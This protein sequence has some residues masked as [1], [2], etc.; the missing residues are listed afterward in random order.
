MTP[1]SFQISSDELVGRI[2]AYYYQP[3]FKLLEEEFKKCPWPLER[4]DKVAT[5]I[6]GSTPKDGSFTTACDDA[7]KFLKTINVQDY[8]LDLDTLYYIS[9]EAHRRRAISALKENDVLINIIGA[10]LEIVGRVTIVPL[11]FGEANINQNIARIRIK[12]NLDLDPYYLMGYLGTKLAQTQIEKLSRQ[13][14]Q[15]NLNTRE[16]GLILIPIPAK[17]IQVEVAEIVRKSSIAKKEAA[18]D[19][20]IA[21]TEFNDHIMKAFGIGLGDDKTRAF[22]VMSTRL[23]F[24]IDAEYYQPHY[25]ELESKLVTRARPLT[26]FVEFSSETIDPRKSPDK[27]FRYVEIENLDDVTASIS[28]YQLVKGSEAPSRARL[29]LRS[30]DIILPSLRGTFK[31]IVVVS[32]EFDGC[33]GTTGFLLLKPTRI[34]PKYLFAILK[35]KIG[36]MQFERAVTGAIMPALAQGELSKILIPYDM[37]RVSE[38]AEAANNFVD[39]TRLLKYR[40][41]TA[42]AV[43]KEKIQRTIMGK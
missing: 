27:E 38:I 13:A 2:D 21:A 31:K 12:E 14:G 37:S 16:V 5:I 28:S 33:I 26:D 23:D 18:K 8:V 29:V 11:A 40:I 19:V 10:T 32:P 22:S 42:T 1:A 17:E 9:S 7:V 15:V 20:E 4:L 3:K 6:C 35:S 43:A 34:D 36:Q 24:R 39:R 41:S 30:G 25:C